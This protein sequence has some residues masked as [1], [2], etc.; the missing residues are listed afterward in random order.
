MAGRCEGVGL[1]LLVR[2]GGW[3][4]RPRPAQK[5]PPPW[6]AAGRCGS[7][8]S[9][10]PRYGA[11]ESRTVRPPLRT[12]YGP[13]PSRCRGH[14][15]L[16]GRR[17]RPARLHAAGSS[18]AGS[19]QAH[20]GGGS[21]ITAMVPER[22]G[23][24]PPL[25]ALSSS[26]RRAVPTPPGYDHGE[27]LTPRSRGGPPPLWGAAGTT[28]AGFFALTQVRRQRQPNRP[29]PPRAPCPDSQ[30]PDHPAT[31]KHPTGCAD[32]DRPT[33]RADVD[34]L[35]PMRRWLPGRPSAAGANSSD[36]PQVS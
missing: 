33:A 7:A 25:R 35:L 26:R 5:P 2:R 8:S 19:G 28:G 31:E 36:R 21:L 24:A 23:R 12:R 10:S 32:S 15:R 1:S 18:S 16:S 13:A 4:D 27:R 34:P 17:T 3:P 29:P 11:R 6:G 30:H 9:P 20:R 22:L 14:R